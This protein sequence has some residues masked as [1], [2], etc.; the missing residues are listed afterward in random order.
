[1]MKLVGRV[2]TLSCYILSY[3][4]NSWLNS[5]MLIKLYQCTY[6]NSV[7]WIKAFF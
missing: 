6:K 4:Y 1:M 5:F 2:I 3:C 7:T